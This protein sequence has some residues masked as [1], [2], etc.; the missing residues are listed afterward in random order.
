MTN[1]KLARF[2]LTVLAALLPLSTA[3]AF[4]AAATPTAPAA[5]TQ[6]NQTQQARPT[7]NGQNQTQQPGMRGGPQGGPRDGQ[8]GQRGPDGGPHAV[9][10]T[11][12]AKALG[13]TTDA[14]R[15]QLQAGKTVAELAKAKG[16]S[17]ATIRSAALAALK[18][19]L[20]A[21][22]KAGKLTQAQADQHLARATADANFGLMAGGPRDGGPNGGNPNGGRGG[23]DNGPRNGPNNGP[24]NRPAP[25]APRGEL[26]T[27]GA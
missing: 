9:I 24:D 1:R 16:V 18:T 15:Q 3:A 21:D 6:R 14:L 11:A 26:P 25:A 8:H 5:Q 4:A 17:T 27:D 2:P 23:P 12:V 19:Q 22:V 20:A 13:L 7:Q 10:D